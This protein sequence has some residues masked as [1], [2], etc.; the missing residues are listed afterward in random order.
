M[1]RLKFGLIGCGTVACYGHLP[2][3]TNLT[4]TD[5][6]AVSDISEAKL[7]EVQEKFGVESV[8]TDYHDL[9][10][11]EDIDAVGIATPLDKHYC[12]VMDAARAGK[13]VLCEKPIAE[14]PEEGMEMVD[15]M[16]SAG[17]LFAI[18]FE[19]RHSEP[20]P[21]LKSLLDDG[22]IGE[23]K[24]LRYIGNWMG[25]RWAGEDRYRMLITEG[26][27]P[28][29][30]C[31]IHHFDSA[32]WLSGSEFAE[33]DAKGTY[34]EDYPN[35]DHVIATCR[36]ENGVLVLIET[37]WAYTHNT[38]CHEANTRMDI[39]GSAGL[40]TYL[41]HTTT[42]AGAESRNE[43]NVYT[44]ETCYRQTISQSKKAF[45]RMYSLFGQS[46]R[47]GELTDLPS[48]YDGVKALEASLQALRKAKGDR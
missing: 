28:I 26:L 27:G 39:I 22:A 32:R 34:I 3:L 9:L 4:D 31:G 45:N 25:G 38:P 46:I 2:A 16:R 48:G 12:V 30:D 1:D 17:R 6:V 7:A 19:L 29:V 40:A 14:S 18:N 33:I 23:L 11:R 35:P 21:T 43:I 8:Y 20:Y 42:I 47:K 37:G 41:S 36:M 13:H 10:A 15:A 24:V 5:L 44:K